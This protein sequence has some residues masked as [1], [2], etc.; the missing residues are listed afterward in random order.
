MAKGGGQMKERSIRLLAVLLGLRMILGASPVAKS[1][2]EDEVR[3]RATLLGF[4]EV[5]AIS[6][7]ASGKFRGEISGDGSS[8]SYTLSYSG[9][10]ATTPT[11]PTVAHIHFGQRGVAAGV[12][13][14]LCGG[15]GKPACPSQSGT[16]TGTVVAADVI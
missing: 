9:F 8:I 13:A 14:F 12:S 10:P 7:A 16:V 5:P 1:D 2:D 6:T 4:E 3:L 15:G 11:S